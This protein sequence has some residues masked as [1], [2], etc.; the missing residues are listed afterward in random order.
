M[1]ALVFLGTGGAWGVPELNCRCAI[2]REMQ[3]RGERRRRTA[4]LLSDRSNLLV[5][6]G[7]DIAS[8]LL[9]HR[10]P[11]PEAVLLTHEHGD[12]YL[13]LDELVAYKRSSPQGQ[14]QPI[15]V[16]LT[17]KAWDVISTRFAYLER[18]GVLEI[19]IVE[20]DCAYRVHEFEAVPFKTF[21]GPLAAGSVGYML[22]GP[23]KS[24]QGFRLVYTS[25]FMELPDPPREIFAPDYLVIQSFWLNEP[26]RNTP[27]HMSFQ[28]AIEFIRRIGPKKETFL[29]HLGDG[30]RVEGDPANVMA[31][32]REPL[33]PLK[34]PG[35]TRPYTVPRCQDEWQQVVDR[36]AADFRIPCKCTVAYDGLTVAL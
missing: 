2:C 23:A 26:A 6:C 1:T 17:A 3:Q 35:G 27:R 21:H 11:K 12:H 8:Q 7:P 4:L 28:R 22:T 18:T 10:V 24:G 33:D 9:E 5:D 31:K 34:P 13:G 36:V 14:F 30:D 16:Y 25:D 32:K 19:R 29:V 20:P 15:P